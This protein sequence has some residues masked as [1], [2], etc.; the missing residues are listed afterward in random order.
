MR[1]LSL[2]QR[3]MALISTALIAAISYGLNR[4]DSY[5]DWQRWRVD[6]RPPEQVLFENQRALFF[7]EYKVAKTDA[8]KSAVYYR[9]VQWTREY[10]ET[11]GWRI[12]NWRGRV[13]K[14]RIVQVGRAELSIYSKYS[15]FG[16]WYKADEPL[17]Q[18]VYNSIAGLGKWDNVIFSGRFKPP[19]RVAGLG[20]TGVA[21]ARASEKSIL[22][23]PAF[24]TEFEQIAKVQD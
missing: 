24:L 11:A 21:E 17:G 2:K 18:Q 20:F 15:R 4:Y 13:F 9:A 23:L 12:N 16:I 3:W 1:K 5:T 19:N 6:R 7:K 22:E 10:A 14:A 8:E